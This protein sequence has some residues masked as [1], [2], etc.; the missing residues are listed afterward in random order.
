MLEV[1]AADCER[2]DGTVGGFVS[3]PPE[4]GGGGG[5]GGGDVETHA[6]VVT[7]SDETD[8]RFPAA[9]YASTPSV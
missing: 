8:D 7:I 9:S 4:G 3:V 5:E 2:F 1:V 6:L